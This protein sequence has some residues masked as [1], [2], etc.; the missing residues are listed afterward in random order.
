MRNQVG[1]VNKSLLILDLNGLLGHMTKNHT[2]Y[3]STGVYNRSDM[4]ATPIHKDANVALYSRPGMVQFTFNFL[5]MKKRIYD[6]G[7]WSSADFDDTKLMVE[8]FF[9]R[10]YTQ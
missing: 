7:V 4:M 8:K 6:V 9:G 3:G 10:Y 2:K 5:V 1:K